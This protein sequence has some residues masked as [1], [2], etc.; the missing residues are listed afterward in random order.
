MVMSRVEN[1]RGL[2]SRSDSDQASA[3]DSA[4]FDL[5]FLCSM[6]RSDTRLCGTFIFFF[7]ILPNRQRGCLAVRVTLLDWCSLKSCLQAEAAAS[8]RRSASASGGS[9]SSN[10][11]LRGPKRG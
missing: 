5:Q 4:L 11:P 3:H 7:I 1:R 8:N 10:R 2:A 9:C 6:E